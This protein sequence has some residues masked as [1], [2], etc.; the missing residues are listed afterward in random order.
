MVLKGWGSPFA[1]FLEAAESLEGRNS[2]P[3][4]GLGSLEPIPESNTVMIVRAF[5]KLLSSSLS[6]IVWLFS[7]FGKQNTY[8]LHLPLYQ[9]P[10]SISSSLN[11]K[12]K[13]KHI[14][15]HPE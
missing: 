5:Q 11:A 7:L 14:N 6:E 8:N 15:N 4:N 13:K 2:S 1:L 10:K 12:T 3:Q 9:V